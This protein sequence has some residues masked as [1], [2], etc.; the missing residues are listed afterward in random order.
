[1]QSCGYVQSCGFCCHCH[2]DACF[3]EWNVSFTRIP[4]DACSQHTY[5]WDACFP[6]VIHVSSAHIS[7]G[8]RVYWI[9]VQHLAIANIHYINVTRF[10]KKGHIY[11]HSFKTHLSSPSVSYINAPTAFV[12]KYCW[13]LNSLLSLRPFSQACLATI[14]AQVAL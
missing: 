11:M 10:A 13:R 1:M 4:R 6:S 7:L 2:R 3:P 9:A 12:F 5:H 14:R 8:M